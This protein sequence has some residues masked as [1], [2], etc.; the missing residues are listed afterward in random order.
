[1][2]LSHRALVEDSTWPRFTLLGQSIGSIILAFEALHVGLVP[3]IWLGPCLASTRP[4][5]A[6]ADV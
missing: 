2:T 1:M 5:S 4:V 3:D 6:G